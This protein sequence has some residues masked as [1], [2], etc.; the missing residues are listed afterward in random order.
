MHLLSI[1]TT[2]SKNEMIFLSKQL[3]VISPTQL[4]ILTCFGIQNPSSG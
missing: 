2:D 3:H 4:Y 1:C